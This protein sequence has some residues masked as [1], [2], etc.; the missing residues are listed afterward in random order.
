M[1]DLDQQLRQIQHTARDL[2]AGLSH[3]Q[4]NWTPERSS[5]SILQCLAHISVSTRLYLTS[6]DKS[7]RQGR[8]KNLFGDRPFEYSRFGR[9]VMRSVEPPPKFRV[10]T[11]RA[12][13]PPAN[14]ELTA[15]LAEFCAMHQQA[16]DTLVRCDG[17]D[18]A[19]CRM[20]HPSLPVLRVSLGLGL[21][22]LTGHARRHLWQAE[23]V[24]KNAGFP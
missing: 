12:Y 18:L 2:L 5:W 11:G 8:M 13:V 22:V 3:V 24:K 14:L 6:I 20:G 15:V 10:K 16:R 17:L 7:I 21:A 4:A 9:W 1:Q 19:R 23:Q